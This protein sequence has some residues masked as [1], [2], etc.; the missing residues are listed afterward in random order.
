[1]ASS[2]AMRLALASTFGWTV[3]SLR[4]R[5][6]VPREAGINISTVRLSEANCDVADGD[7]QTCGFWA[8][9][10][11]RCRNHGC[12][13]VQSS[14]ADT[15]WCFLSAN[16]APAP[17]PSAQC[18]MD[19]YVRRDCSSGVSINQESCEAKG[20]C[21]SAAV[22]A[23]LP[24]CFYDK[25]TAT[26]PTPTP[27]PPLPGDFGR[28]PVV[29]QISTR[30]WLYELAL[31]GHPANCTNG[32]G[33][34]YVCLKDVPDAE[35]Q[36]IKDDKT[37]I[38]WLMGVWQLGNAGLQ[39]SIGYIDRYKTELPDITVE[40]IIGSPY[41]IVD[42]TVNSEIGTDADLD[43]VKAKL[44]ALGMGLMVDF[45]PNHFA[46]D[47]RMLETNPEVF[48]QRPDGDTSPDEWWIEKSGVT[49]AYGRG[50]Y[51]GPWT[52]TLNVNYWSPAAIAIMKDI[53]VNIAK[54]VDAIRIDMA[55]LVLNDVWENA[56]SDVMASGGWARPEADFWA[57]AISTAKA[58][59]S[60]VIVSE[61]YDYYMTS[62]P[63][64]E[65]LT[66]LGV[67]YSYNKKVLDVIEEQH[68]DEM[69]GFLFQQPQWRLNRMCHFVENHDEP[70]AAKSLGGQAK[71]FAA[72]VAALTLPGMRLTYFGQ[73]DGLANRLGV[74]LRRG[75]PED[76]HPEVH[77][78]YVK[79]MEAL[80]HEVFHE[81]TWTIIDVEQ[82]GPEWR[83]FAWGW[84]HNG[85][86]RLVVVNWCD[87]QGV[88]IVPVAN[89][90]GHED[91]GRVQITELLTNTTLN[92]TA[93][94]MR[95]SG[96]AV[97]LDPWKAHIFEYSAE[98]GAKTLF[99]AAPFGLIL[100]SL[101]LGHW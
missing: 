74:H 13:Y 89:A 10:A 72:S 63:E 87:Q 64:Q 98:D 59:T 85:E 90:V 42:Y 78:Q 34:D 18:T 33:T 5:K 44:N 51:D 24:D 73:Y 26:P 75:T 6:G 36:K 14:V 28:S 41:A 45:V 101:L 91:S 93:T 25:E 66:N 100:L 9:G 12:C 69:R 70:R 94:E 46:L 95:G 20:C 96:L 61:A 16:H 54:R 53:F 56:W 83:L 68:L 21:W 4:K 82:P 84:E 97:Q 23:W 49:V 58:E 37:N 50:P 48:I 22:A 11:D 55:M 1:M 31:A 92:G 19:D 88:G 71:A 67:D 32:R 40:D 79:L 99:G 57:D 15:P 76:K 27:S 47:A 17:A 3:S 39:D 62:P 7:K 81:G 60:L 80:S 8:I 2:I 77:A 52:D 35:W 30:P 65:Y 86:K 43:A 38:V 29:Y